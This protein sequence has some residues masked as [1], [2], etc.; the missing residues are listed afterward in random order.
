MENRI[1]TLVKKLRRF[2]YAVAAQGPHHYDPVCGMEATRDFFTLP[3]EGKKYYFCSDHCLSQF[4]ISPHQ[5][6]G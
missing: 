6:P 2:G 4:K 3:Y 5:Y 1:K